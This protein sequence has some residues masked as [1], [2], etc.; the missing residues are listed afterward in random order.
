M[1]LTISGHHL[2]VTPSIREY[3]LNK[4]ERVRR[5][6]DHVIDIT[7]ILSV[8]KLNQR[9][10]MTL[11]MSGKDIHVEAIHE[12]MYAAL[13]LLVDKLDRQVCKHKEKVQAHARDAIKHQEQPTP[14]IP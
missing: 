2:D 4:L 5:H 7:V 11:H 3:V 8:E 1:N 6:F 10:E 9:A 13:D 12:D 14:P